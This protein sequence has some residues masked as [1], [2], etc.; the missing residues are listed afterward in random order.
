[1][2]YEFCFQKEKGPGKLKGSRTQEKS[3]LYA[4]GPSRDVTYTITNHQSQLPA[5]KPRFMSREISTLLF[6]LKKNTVR[7]VCVLAFSVSFL[8]AN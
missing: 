8:R 7:T 4:V 1:M 5:P 2:L 6:F 3:Y